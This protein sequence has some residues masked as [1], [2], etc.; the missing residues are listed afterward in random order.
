MW[1]ESND[2]PD[3][4]ARLE[5]KVE[6]LLDVMQRVERNVRQ[7]TDVTQSLYGRIESMHTTTHNNAVALGDRVFA[8]EAA[9]W[10]GI[11]PK[12]RRQG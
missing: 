9:V 1:S 10:R 11:G 6:Q 8:M 2:H 12:R 3:R 5:R 4:L 7:L